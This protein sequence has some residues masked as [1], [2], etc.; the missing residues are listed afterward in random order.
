MAPI[1]DLTM[2]ETLKGKWAFRSFH[3]EPIVVKDGHVA[4]DP[5][6]AEPWTPPGTL[7]VDTD[8]RGE[9][10]GKLTFPPGAVLAITGRIIPA[11]PAT[12]TT[13]EVPAGVEL[14]GTG[15]GLPAVY[16][17]KGFFVPGSDHVVGTVLSMANDL[18]RQPVGTAGAFALFPAKA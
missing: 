2:N 7:V 17:V 1:E 6:L 15:V 9:V 12:S 10:T 18:A 11:K 3:H 14:T 8:E 4:G 13:L 5:D 16:E